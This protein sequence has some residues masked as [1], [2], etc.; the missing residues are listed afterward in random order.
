MLTDY[1]AQD[2]DISVSEMN[3]YLGWPGQAISYKLG[4]QAIRDLRADAQRTLG[5]AFDLKAF[6]SR[7]LEIGAPGLRVVREHMTGQ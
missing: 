3:R 6:H 1:A 4:Q 7:L 5:P 2:H